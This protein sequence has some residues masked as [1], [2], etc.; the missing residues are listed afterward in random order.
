MKERAFIEGVQRRISIISVSASALRNQGASGI[1]DAS[2][3]YFHEEIKLVDFFKAVS[4]SNSYKRYLDTHTTKLLK[5]FPSSGKSWGA[6]RKGLNL[7]F[8]EVV[9][10][11]FISDYYG[12]PNDINKFN[13]M[14]A[15][16]EVPLDRDVAMGI[17]QNSP[18]E[19]P[20]WKS[21]RE[22]KKAKSEL[23]QEAANHI[24]KEKGTIR[25]HLDLIYWRQQNR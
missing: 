8:R 3:L 12:L 11:K 24:A 5:T 22:L 16:L 18:E 25:I 14:F 13:K 6:A 4:S 10:N 1:V 20:E 23:Y 15:Y 17:R 21:I 9:Y 19:L 7:Y 2:R